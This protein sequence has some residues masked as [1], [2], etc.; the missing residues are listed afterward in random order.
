MLV[1]KFSLLNAVNVA[2]DNAVVPDISKFLNSDFTDDRRIRGD[3]ALL[4]LRLQ[5]VERKNSPVFGLLI[6]HGEA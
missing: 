3:P 2:S 4:D 6:G 1:D 5:I